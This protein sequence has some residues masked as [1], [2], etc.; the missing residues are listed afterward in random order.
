MK[1]ISQD[2]LTYALALL[3]RVLTPVFQRRIARLCVRLVA[4]V[5]QLGTAWVVRFAEP[6]RSG[7]AKSDAIDAVLQQYGRF[8]R[9]QGHI[10][11]QPGDPF[12]YQGTIKRNV[13]YGTFRRK[14]S[15]ILAGTGTFVLKISADSRRLTGHCTWYDNLLDDVWSSKYVWTRSG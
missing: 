11:G 13:F 3:A 4:D 1:R 6:S 8:L 5:P 2:A 10:Q 9:G 7:P 14:D 15:H 12:E